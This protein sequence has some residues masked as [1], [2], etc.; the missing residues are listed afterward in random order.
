ME[1]VTDLGRAVPPWIDR[2]IRNRV[3]AITRGYFPPSTYDTEARGQL[4]I[5]V[6]VE[7][8]VLGS[9]REEQ[10]SVTRSFPATVTI[11]PPDQ[12]SAKPVI[13]PAAREAMRTGVFARGLHVVIEKDGDEIR[14]RWIE[15]MF[16]VNAPPYRV[17]ARVFARGRDGIWRPVYPDSIV[18]GRR[19]FESSLPL[20]LSREQV[21]D[22]LFRPNPE[23]AARELDVFDYWGEDIILESVPVSP[24]LTYRR[25]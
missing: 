5:R 13:D 4:S 14:G 25:R 15:G 3:S 10:A 8:R 7:Y 2:D 6:E 24:V 21:V 9:T 22:F 11:L 20:E 19:A 16:G 1:R 18:P 23:V 12:P 17:A